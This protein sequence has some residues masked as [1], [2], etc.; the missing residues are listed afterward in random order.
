VTDALYRQV[1][2]IRTMRH[3]YGSAFG[4]FQKW[5]AGSLLGNPI[6]MD[7]ANGELH[8]NVYGLHRRSYTPVWLDINSHTVTVVLPAGA[9]YVAPSSGPAVD[10]IDVCQSGPPTRVDDDFQRAPDYVGAE[11]HG[12][13]Y[14]VE[15]VEHKPG[16]T[17]SALQ[18]GGEDLNAK[19]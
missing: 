8:V 9:V 12:P 14:A 18:E 16:E 5:R 7:G 13:P 2:R 3:C 4:L 19:S 6:I 15:F 10:N 11:W 17:T 1:L